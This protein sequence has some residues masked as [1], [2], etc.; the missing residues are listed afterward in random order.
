[1][2]YWRKQKRVKKKRKSS[3]KQN[4]KKTRENRTK[5]T[6][7]PLEGG[8]LVRINKDA[9]NH[10]EICTHHT[11]FVFGSSVMCDHQIKDLNTT[12]D[13]CCEIATDDFGRVSPFFS[14]R[15]KRI[16][17]NIVY[18]TTIPQYIHSYIVITKQRNAYILDI[19]RNCCC[20]SKNKLSWPI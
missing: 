18:I 9:S 14:V 10:E 3:F 5:D 12:S 7:F 13:Y 17:N 19:H 1:M 16:L 20:H 4:E 11:K 15:H 8:R 6:M 2:S